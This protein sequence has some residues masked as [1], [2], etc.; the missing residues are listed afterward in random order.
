V[1]RHQVGQAV[2]RVAGDAGQHVVEIRER[3]DPVPLAGGDEA[4]E[5]GNM[6]ETWGRYPCFEG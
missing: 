2:V 6:G 1:G 4:E 5:D 3:L